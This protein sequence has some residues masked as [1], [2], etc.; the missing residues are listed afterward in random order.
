MHVSTLRR[1]WSFSCSSQLSMKFVLANFKMP[2][3]SYQTFPDTK[4][5]NAKLITEYI[6]IKSYLGT[7]QAINAVVNWIKETATIA[8]SVPTKQEAYHEIWPRE[9]KTESKSMKLIV[10]TNVKMSTLLEILTFISNINTPYWITKPG[11]V[12]AL[13]EGF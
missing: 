9:Y 5:N 11:A 13:N 4:T 3:T 12:H 10:L 6:M 8:L 2:T 1:L 7:R